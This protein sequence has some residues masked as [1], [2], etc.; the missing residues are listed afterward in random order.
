MVEE[1][2][3]LFQVVFIYVSGTTDTPQNNINNCLK[4]I[5]KGLF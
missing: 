2:N 3:Q 4:I 5:L 1:E